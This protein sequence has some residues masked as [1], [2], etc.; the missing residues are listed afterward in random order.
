MASA[1]NNSRTM[2]AWVNQHLGPSYPFEG[3][4]DRV[5]VKELDCFLERMHFLMKSIV[6]TTVADEAVAKISVWRSELA[7]FLAPDAEPSFV[8]ADSLAMHKKRLEIL[9]DQLVED[10]EARDSLA[11]ETCRFATGRE[12]TTNQ[13]VTGVAWVTSK[14]QKERDARIL[15]KRQLLIA[16]QMRDEAKPLKSSKKGTRFFDK[17]ARRAKPIVCVASAAETAQHEESSL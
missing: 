9:R 16:S 5:H 8:T 6:I 10:E 17:E 13:E 7:P 3:V 4:G 14:L 15:A 1:T 11:R 2:L 12:P